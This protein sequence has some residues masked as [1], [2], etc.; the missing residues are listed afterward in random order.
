MKSYLKNQSKKGE[1]FVDPIYDSANEQERQ[2][3]LNDNKT[4]WE[5]NPMRYDWN[6]GVK[7]EEFSKPFYEEI[8]KRFLD[9]SYEVMPWKKI[10]FDYYINFEDIKSKKVLEIGVG[11]GTH[12]QILASNCDD[13]TGIDLTS[14]GQKSTSER[15]KV[16]HI[17]NANIIQMNAEELAFEDN[18]FDFIWSWGVIHH[19]ANTTR[20]MEQM[21]RVLKQ[22]GN[23][24]IMVYHRG[25][26]NYYFIG[27]LFHGLL[28]GDIFRTK[29]LHRTMQDATD[30]A[31]ARYYTKSE[32]KS[33]LEKIGFV[34][35]KIEIVGSKIELLPIPSGKVKNFLYKLIPDSF[36]RFL[37]NKCGMGAMLVAYFH[38]N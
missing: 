10:P 11:N 9:A 31:I 3:L 35:D 8:D 29:S 30:G 25:F 6:E 18:T 2:E 34:V 36:G 24:T 38:K 26:F 16:F 20:I 33:V 37:T 1:K 28:K 23:S 13:Y 4:W 15:M 17:A 32:M 7:H 5:K 14:Y 12:A 22:G 27:F 19:S 21:H